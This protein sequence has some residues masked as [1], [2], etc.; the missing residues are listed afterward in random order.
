MAR[1]DNW[2]TGNRTPKYKKA[3]PMEGQNGFRTISVALAGDYMFLHG[4]QT[5]GEVRVYTTDSFNM[6]GKMVP[7]TEVG[8]NSETGWGDV[9]YT[10][11]AWK[12]Q[13][14]EYVVCI[15]E[16][17]KAKFLVYRWKPEAGIV[18]GYPEIEITSPTNRAFTGQGNHIVLEVQTKDNGSI[19]KVEYFAG[20]T[21][22]GER[23]RNHF[24]LPGPV[25][26]KAST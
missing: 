23:P 24:L 18:E 22:L 21:L 13:N 11:D 15:E 12:R 14:G 4:E 1:I 25:P 2:S 7:G 16:D 10:I 9:P 19:A 5:R 3:V 17:A 26:A 8:G 6:A 20:D